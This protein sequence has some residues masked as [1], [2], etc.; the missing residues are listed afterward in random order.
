MRQTCLGE[1]AGRALPFRTLLA[2]FIGELKRRAERAAGHTFESAVFGRPVFF[3]DDSASADRQAEDTL[4]EIA[5]GAGSKDVRF[6]F[7]RWQRSIGGTDKILH[8]A[9]AA[10]KEALKTLEPIIELAAALQLSLEE[11]V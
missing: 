6:Q 9:P 8:L 4:A 1:V 10:R 2:Q 3:I 11:L 5:R 7:E